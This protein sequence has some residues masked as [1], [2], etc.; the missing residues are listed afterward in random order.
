MSSPKTIS[1][2]EGLARLWVHE[3]KRV[4]GDRLTCDEDHHWLSALL[5]LKIE[6]DQ[7]SAEGG[8]SGSNGSSGTGSGGSGGGSG[9]GGA[10]FGVDYSAVVTR[11]RI[12]Y[13]DFM[14]GDSDNKV[15]GSGLMT[16]I[17]T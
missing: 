5:R 6:G 10:G 9:A 13:G 11:E 7:G 14:N 12:V 16:Y 1:S 2:K 17:H 15:S 4:F 8:S 3:C